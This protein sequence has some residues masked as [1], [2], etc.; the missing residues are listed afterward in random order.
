MSDKKPL[1]RTH[2]QVRY[3]ECDPSGIVFH[4][5]Y[6]TWADMASFE[7]LE[8]IVGPHA[9]LADRGLELVVADSQVRYVVPTTA[10]DELVVAGFLE[11]VGRT[12]MVLRFDIARDESLVAEVTN[13]YVW[14]SPDAKKPVAPAA[15]LREKL[16]ARL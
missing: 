5:N 9:D 10:G 11:H 3:H 4:P 2:I 1:T 6:L 15:D 7:C 14:V 12:S 8:E 16:V 13:R